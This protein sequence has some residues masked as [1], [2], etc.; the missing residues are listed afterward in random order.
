MVMEREGYPVLEFLA[1]KRESDS[2]FWSIPEIGHDT[3]LDLAPVPTTARQVGLAKNE[4]EKKYKISP[5]E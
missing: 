3:H 5:V 4:E 2:M 1:I